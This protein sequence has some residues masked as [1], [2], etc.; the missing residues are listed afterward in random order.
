IR[1]SGYPRVSL[2]KGIQ[3]VQGNFSLRANSLSCR[4]CCMCGKLSV[5]QLNMWSRRYSPTADNPGAPLYP[6]KYEDF[7]GTPCRKTTLHCLNYS[8]FLIYGCIQGLEC[9]KLFSSDKG[10]FAP[11]SHKK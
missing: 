3:T 7:W 4:S 9:I 1:V 8:L 11:L 10:I 6:K 2:F 5:F